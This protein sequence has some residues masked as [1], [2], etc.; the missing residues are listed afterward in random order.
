[1]TDMP[2]RN[3]QIIRQFLSAWSRLDPQE[4]AGFFTDDGCYFN[5]PTQPVTGRQN[6]ET[7]IRGFTADWT[8]TTWEIRSIA[9]IADRVYAERMDRTRT[10]RGHVDLPC[11]GV[12]E[13]QDGKIR[14]WRD[15][16]DLATFMRPLQE[17]RG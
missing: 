6:I 10:S 13:L 9:A 1:M 14:E 8:S 12:F 17:G 5:I 15:Y 16:F 4:L 2:S 11:L 7:F 3:E